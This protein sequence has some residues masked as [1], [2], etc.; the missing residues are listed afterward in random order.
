MNHAH[1]HPPRTCLRWIVSSTLLATAC[2][3]SSGG[4][5]GTG[6]APGTGGA[7]P[8]GTGGQTSLGTGGTNATGGSAPAS[9][10]STASTG[11]AGG[12]AS[13]TG[14]R[15]ATGGASGAGTG[16]AG[17][18][19]P[20]PGPCVLPVGTTPSGTTP[21]QAPATAQASTATRPQLSQTVVD[22][23][24]TIAKFL[25]RAGTVAS[26]FLSGGVTATTVDT[27][28]VDSWDPVT[29]GIGDVTKLT[30]MFTVAS[31]GSGTHQKVQDAITAAA[32]IPAATCARVYIA[33]KPGTYREVVIV[34]KT[35]P[36]ITLY[37]TA[38]DA[39]R[40]VIV[41]NNPA[42]TAAAAVLGTSGSATFTQN[43]TAFQAK[44]LTFSNDYMEVGGATANEQAVAFLNQGDK[45]QLENTRFL[46]N[47]D[48]LYLKTVNAGTIARAYLR[49]SYIEGDTDFIFGRGTS[50]FDHCEIKTVGTNRTTGTS[51][52]APSTEVTNKYG[53]LFISSKFTADANVTA[54][55]LARQWFEGSRPQAVG[56]MIVR[57][58]T[59]GAHI[60][61]AA[62]WKAWAGRC[63]TAMPDASKLCPATD[64]VNP[65]LYASGDYYLAGG[66]PTPAEP[67]LGEYGNM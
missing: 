18:G 17:G 64:P 26:S 19:N 2:G 40:T 35:A 28:V 4:S 29:S 63:V 13:S 58:S 12:T 32:A 48:T 27:P 31:D 53:F 62:P 1:R 47:Q 67:Y 50:V 5:T 54:A 45:L 14:G 10:G 57:N 23:E 25:A 24:Y 61:A 65:I 51:A 55:S 33:V 66:G 15:P 34:P 44:N 59:I 52:A 7:T 9:G 37:G 42:G 43:A 41:F 60:P 8:G 22:A 56:K 16:G 38:A 6:G 21:I 3:G 49:D 39:S 36:P 20:L 11:G 46:G 30:P